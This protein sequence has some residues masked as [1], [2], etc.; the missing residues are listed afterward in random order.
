[1]PELAK[2]TG[3]ASADLSKGVSMGQVT[4]HHRNKLRPAGEPFRR[5]FRLVPGGKVMELKHPLPIGQS[6]SL[7]N[8]PMSPIFAPTGNEF[9]VTQLRL[10][11]SPFTLL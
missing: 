1:M 10:R 9:S 7:A 11:V 8:N 3:K 2:A 6:S 4:E 5:S